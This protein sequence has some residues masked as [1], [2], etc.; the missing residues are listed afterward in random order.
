[1]KISNQNI[2]KENKINFKEPIDFRTRL[3]VTKAINE[4]TIIMI[5]KDF[6]YQKHQTRE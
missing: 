5:A 6:I 2:S 4:K 1:M 3:A